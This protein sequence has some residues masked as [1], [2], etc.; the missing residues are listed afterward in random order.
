M[1]CAHLG[2]TGPAREPVVT[3]HRS[4]AVRAFSL[5]CLRIIGT[6]A[7]FPLEKNFFLNEPNLLSFHLCDIHVAVGCFVLTT[8]SCL[9]AALAS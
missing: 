1:E 4:V 9:D 8:Y 2:V 5:F 7:L 6:C 3:D